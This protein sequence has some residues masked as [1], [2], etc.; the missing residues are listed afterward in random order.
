M[1]IRSLDHVLP[2]PVAQFALWFS[3]ATACKAIEIPEAMCLST[4]GAEGFPDGRMVLLKEFSPSGFV[5]YT[6]LGSQKGRAL[7]RVAKAALTFHWPA[8]ERQVRIQGTTQLVSPA[9]A[10]AYFATRPRLSQIGAWASEQSAVLPKREILDQR[11]EEWSKK[12][13][14]QPVP[15]P[16]HWTGV[17]VEPIRL[18]FWQG[19]ANRLHDRFLYRKDASGRWQ[20][21][22][23]F[24]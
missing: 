18:E 6:N 21:Q 10:D 13:A 11:V 8:L 20:V 19:R 24:P 7:E 23:L 22:R 2:D 1:K 4:V 16:P 5:F 3:E 14:G 17:R 9:E 15:R 12:F